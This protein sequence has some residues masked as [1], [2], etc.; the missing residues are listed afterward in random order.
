MSEKPL[1]SVIV[2]VHDHAE[3]ISRCL[4]SL[5][6]Q[7]YKNFEII[8]VDDGSTDGSGD[9][10]REFAEK[11]HRIKYFR[12]ENGGASAA[13]NSGLEA[14]RGEWIGFC[15]SDDYAEPDM[16][17]Y[18]L[19]LARENSADIAQCGY[20]F[21]T[22]DSSEACC[23]PA[24]D[25]VIDDFANADTGALRYFA[26][27]CWCKLFSSSILRDIRFEDYR[28]GEDLLFNVNA[29][30]AAD[31]TVL[32]GRAG[33]HYIQYGGSICH[34]APTTESLV[35]FRA[36]LLRI[37]SLLPEN[38]AA[39]ARYFDELLRDGFDIC[40]KYVRYRPENSERAVEEV[41]R[42]LKEN[43]KYISRSDGFSR[44][45]KLKARLI[46]RA[47]PL[48]SRLIRAKKRGV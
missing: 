40:S 19:A 23:V 4:A 44:K 14:A 13:R 27:A 3:Y 25:I 39:H 21:D 5:A 7:T 32:G 12:R 42:E 11:D 28:I 35:S 16:L 34:S 20:Y 33:Y 10:C 37:S 8:A 31:R 45:E 9:I 41:R 38:S 17:E 18:L 29:A 30:L 36:V 24:G 15:D 2:P 6:C 48:Y 1:I 47:W 26:N 43:L 22:E 46:T